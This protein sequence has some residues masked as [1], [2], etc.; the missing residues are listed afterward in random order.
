MNLNTLY[1]EFLVIQAAYDSLEWTRVVLACYY[2]ESYV[3]E[4][5]PAPSLSQYIY[6]NKERL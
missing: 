3:N 6:E 1:R 5:Y 2:G 4:R